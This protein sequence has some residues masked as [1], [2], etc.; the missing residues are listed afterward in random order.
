MAILKL[1]SL[2]A[3]TGLVIPKEMLDKLKVASGD[4]LHVIETP[5]GFLL[6]PCDSEVARELEIGRAFM[7]QYEDTFKALAK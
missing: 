1:E 2:G 4:S 7:K 5:D 3:S 6:V